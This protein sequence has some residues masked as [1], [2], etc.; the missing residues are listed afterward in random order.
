MEL[1]LRIRACPA[2][3]HI[4]RTTIRPFIRIVT[5]AELCEKR[6]YAR[7]CVSKKRVARNYFVLM[8]EIVTAYVKHGKKI[9]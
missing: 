3:T 8:K 9:L 4:P 1:L 2:C 6:E 5:G 7:V